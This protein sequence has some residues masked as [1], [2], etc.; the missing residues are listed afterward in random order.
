MI[1]F[2]LNQNIKKF[3]IEGKIDMDLKCKIRKTRDQDKIKLL[4]DK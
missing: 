4:G 3:K 2:F 1:A